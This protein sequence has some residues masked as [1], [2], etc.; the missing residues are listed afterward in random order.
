[1]AAS[2]CRDQDRGVSLPRTMATKRSAK[3]VSLGPDAKTIPGRRRQVGDIS[4]VY[5][6]SVAQM[7]TE[8]CR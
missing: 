8:P 3:L 7:R 5:P 6:G 4:L 1:M 2:R